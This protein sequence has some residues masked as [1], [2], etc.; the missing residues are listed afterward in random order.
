[1]PFSV[2]QLSAITEMLENAFY[3]LD[4]L[5]LHSITTKLLGRVEKLEEEVSRSFTKDKKQ[6]KENVD[7]VLMGLKKEDKANSST[8]ISNSLADIQSS[9]QSDAAAAYMPIE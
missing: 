3:G 6:K 1:M 2:L 9:L 7:T 4:L 5:K 8:S